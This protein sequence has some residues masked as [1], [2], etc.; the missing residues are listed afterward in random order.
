MCLFTPRG[1]Y[2]CKH[3]SINRR[4]NDLFFYYVSMLRFIALVMLITA[5][6]NV[7]KH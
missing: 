6:N 7:K 5:V 1:L 4:E 3:A 2:K